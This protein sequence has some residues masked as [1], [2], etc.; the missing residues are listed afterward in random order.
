VFRPGASEEPCV[1]FSISRAVG[2]AV[3]R[4]RARRRLR[5]AFATLVRDEPQRYAPGHYL[6][7]VRGAGW[8]Y[9]QGAT[10]LK[11]ALQKVQP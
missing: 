2:T 5:A 4:N 1:A 10:W 9:Q 11:S 3:V 6:I 7:V 8:D